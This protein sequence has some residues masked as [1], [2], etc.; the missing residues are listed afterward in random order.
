MLQC[1]PD[2]TGY[3]RKLE[4]HA[5]QSRNVA[6]LRVMKNAEVTSL[7]D[8]NQ[9]VTHNQANSTRIM[10]NEEKRRTERQKQ[11][12]IGRLAGKTRNVEATQGANHASK[13]EEK[14]STATEKVHERAILSKRKREESSQ[15]VRFGDGKKKKKREESSRIVCR[16]EG[17]QKRKNE[18]ISLATLTGDGKRKKAKGQTGSEEL[19]CSTHK[20]IS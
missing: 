19:G 8:K 2:C 1:K 13:Q 3:K 6:K 11:L 10:T 14:H 17:K 18:E 16:G 12:A 20:G 5:E 4:S 15:V 9:A 7:K